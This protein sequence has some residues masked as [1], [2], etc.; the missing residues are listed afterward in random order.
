MDAV[1]TETETEHPEA[2]QAGRPRR[3]AGVLALVSAIVLALDIVSKVVVVATREGDPPLKLLGGAVYFYVVRNSGAAFSIGTGM[4]WVFSVVMIVVAVAVGVFATRVRS[5]GWAIGLGMVLAGALGNLVDRI[6]RAPGPFQ[7]RVVD[8]ISLFAPKGGD[9]AIFNVAD[10]GITLGVAL[11][12]V[13]SVLVHDY[14]GSRAR[15]HRRDA[16]PG[17]EDRA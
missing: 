11:I 7:G 4:T 5:I 17:G 12:V 6:F 15:R 3:R 16:H 13:L 9:F 14:D 10:S 1:S 2:P 8:F